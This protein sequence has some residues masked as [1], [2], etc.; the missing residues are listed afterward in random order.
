MALTYGFYNSLNG[1]RKYNAEQFGSIFDGVIHDGVY[2]S[3]G[4]RMMVRAANNGMN[5]NI[6]TGRAWFLHTWTLNDTIYVL[7]LPSAEPLLDKWVAVVLDINKDTGYRRNAFTYVAG[8]PASNPTYP[9]LVNTA[10]HKQVPLAYV[11]IKAGSTAITQSSIVNAVGTS[12][13]PF[14]TGVVTSMNI[15]SLI[16][17]WQTQWNEWMSGN[18]AEY[19]DFRSQFN[20]FQ[21]QF[22]SFMSSSESS[23]D[24]FMDTKQSEFLTFIDAKDNEFDGALDD[25][26]E[27]FSS[28]WEDFKAGM[29]E[30]LQTQ[31][32]I[33]ENWFSRIRGQLDTDAAT[34]LQAQIDAL[35]YAY[36]LANRAVL[37]VTAFH[38]DNKAVFGAW[39]SVAGSRV[40]VARPAL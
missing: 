25:M 17:Q 5:V 3:I 28:F 14:V 37:G 19:N 21:N 24:S 1:D 34:R 36:V 10:S 6:Q 38:V 8:T 23:F 27:D 39:G 11:R 35:A 31:E 33:W 22:I 29:E 30:Y 7:T 2:S 12:S 16:A 32:V 13:C 15:D 9:A 20:A 18:T 26:R 40:I 4:G